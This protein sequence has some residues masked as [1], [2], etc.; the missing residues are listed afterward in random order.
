MVVATAAVKLPFEP[1]SPAKLNGRLG[2]PGSVPATL[3]V[4]VPSAFTAVTDTRTSL[5]PTPITATRSVPFT[6]GTTSSTRPSLNVAF[7]LVMS[8]VREHEGAAIVHRDENHRGP[9]TFVQP[10]QRHE[11]RSIRI[12]IHVLGVVGGGPNFGGAA[13]SDF[14]TSKVIS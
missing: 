1:L 12:R 10:V 5:R 7:T 14:F 13:S 8:A 6:V 3:V 11:N 2:S 4:S 9:L